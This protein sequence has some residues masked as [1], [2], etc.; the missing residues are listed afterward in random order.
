V[1]IGQQVADKSQGR[2][3]SGGGGGGRGRATVR[4]P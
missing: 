2:I 3:V 4:A 1:E